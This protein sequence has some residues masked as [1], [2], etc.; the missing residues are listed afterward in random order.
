MAAYDQYI[1]QLEE[2]AELEEVNA[3]RTRRFVERTDPFTSYS[4]KE[5]LERFML[6]KTCVNDLLENIQEQLPTSSRRRGRYNFNA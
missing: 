1:Q 3:R 4:D 6:S 5:F 2:I